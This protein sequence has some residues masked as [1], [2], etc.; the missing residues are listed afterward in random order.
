MEDTK[1][2]SLSK[3]DRTDADRN[4]HELSHYAQG[5]QGCAQDGILELKG[6]V[7]TQPSP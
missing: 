2:I 1:E 3:H 4:S 6:E 5:L 7:G